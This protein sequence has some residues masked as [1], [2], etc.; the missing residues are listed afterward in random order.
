MATIKETTK[1]TTG[2]LI[3]LIVIF[4]L[5]VLWL[6]CNLIRFTGNVSIQFLISVF[7]FVVAAFYVY[8]G[9][10]KPHGNLMRYLVLLYAIS[11]AGFVVLNASI[12]PAFLNANY[13]A[14]IIL[15]TYMAGRLKHYKQNIVLGA[16]VLICNCLTTIYFLGELSKTD[17]LTFINA[18]SCFGST[19]IWL[20]IAGGYITRY[21]LHKEAGLADK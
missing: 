13:L 12:Q 21:K 4:A 1:L 8:F 3:A 17:T 2:Q 5:N 14:V 9:Y 15:T 11:I 18:V 16:I 20:A 7:M 6:V 19:T 10:K